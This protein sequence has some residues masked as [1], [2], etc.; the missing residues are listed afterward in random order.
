VLSVGQG[1]ATGP[2]AGSPR[3]AARW[4]KA[5]VADVEDLGLTDAVRV[6]TDA[7]RVLTDAVLAGTVRV[8]ATRGSL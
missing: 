1:R 7:V 6:L 3:Q 2:G 8:L 5:A 4:P